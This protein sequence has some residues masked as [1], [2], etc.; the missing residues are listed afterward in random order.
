MLSEESKSKSIYPKLPESTF[1]GDAS[2]GKLLEIH[3]VAEAKWYFVYA[4]YENKI[5]HLGEIERGKNKRGF[6][7]QK[8][9]FTSSGSRLGSSAANKRRN[10]E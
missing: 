3:C 1:F 10:N 8:V 4:I 7:V 6:Q 9:P 5:V 2:W